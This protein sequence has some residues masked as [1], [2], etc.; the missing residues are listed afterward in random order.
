MINHELN[1]IFVHIPKC[2]GCSIKKYLIENSRT[3]TVWCGHKPLHEIMEMMRAANSKKQLKVRVENYY[4]FTFVRN[5]WDRIIS[6]YSFWS[7]Q[8]PASP[9]YKW[10]YE[11]ANFIKSKNLSFKDFVKLI[12]SDNSIFHERP[13]LYPYLGHFIN[14]PSSFN[15]IGKLEN[16]K[17]DFYS[18][19]AQIGIPKQ[20]LPWTNKSNR[21][22]RTAYYDD[23]TRDIIGEQ[24]AKDIEYFG[25]K[26][27]E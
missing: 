24:Y 11:Q 2:G 17:E 13:H 7:N 19:C 1:Y 26:F 21:K 16:F 10:D 15:F 23:E 4:K 8:P 27:G 18:V 12:S 9:F 5:P 6:L 20:K 25:Y 22:C 3:E 14:C